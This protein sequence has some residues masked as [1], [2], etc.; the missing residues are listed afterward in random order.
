MFGCWGVAGVWSAVA[1]RL[2]GEVN[3]GGWETL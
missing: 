1:R 2:E 3:A